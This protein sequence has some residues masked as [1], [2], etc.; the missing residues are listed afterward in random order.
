MDRRARMGSLPSVVWR[1]RCTAHHNR[2]I[3]FGQRV[4]PVARFRLQTAIGRR[5]LDASSRS[6]GGAGR[7]HR[8]PISSVGRQDGSRSQRLVR[9]ER[10]VSVVGRWVIAPIHSRLVLLYTTLA[11]GLGY[12]DGL[13]EKLAYLVDWG[14]W[15][16][17]H[18]VDGA[19]GLD[20]GDNDQD[21]DAADNAVQ[22]N[23]GE[24]GIPSAARHLERIQW[25]SI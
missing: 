20:D 11:I 15:L 3:G 4:G 18:F 25:V 6:V 21:D 24:A 2:L 7:H 23:G 17:R 16:A 8:V 13:N 9:L 1:R 14:R 19:R 5:P 22:A 12:R 10:L